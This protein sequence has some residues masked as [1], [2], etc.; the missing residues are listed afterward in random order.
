MTPSVVVDEA[1]KNFEHLPEKALTMEG[2][3][4]VASMGV[5][6]RERADNSISSE[7]NLRT[8]VILTCNLR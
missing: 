3:T 6:F 8:E 5:R 2:E 7:S 4:T 1:D